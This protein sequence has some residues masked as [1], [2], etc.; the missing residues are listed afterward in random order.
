MHKKKL[1][2]H[3]LYYDAAN[4][5]YFIIIKGKIKYVENKEHIAK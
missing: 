4:K 1:I 5:K 2:H 3:K